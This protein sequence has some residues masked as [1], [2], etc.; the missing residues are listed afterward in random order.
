MISTGSG[1]RAADKD[2]RIVTLGDSITRGVRQGVK[3]EETFSAQ[4]QDRLRKEGAKV[5]VINLG[6]GG[7]RS[8]QALTRLNAAVIAQKPCLVAIMYGTN[9]S[10]V[11]QGKKEPRLTAE[12]YGMNLRKLVAELRRKGIEP[13]LMTPPRWGA[14]A[15]NGAADNPNI[16]LDQFVRVCRVVA[17]ETKTPLVDHN[18]HWSMSS[19]R[20]IDIGE[21]TTDQCHPNPRGHRELAELMLPFLRDRV[22]FPP[23]GYLCYRATR[24][25]TIDGK[26]DEAAWKDA[27]WSDL[28]VDIEGDRKPRPRYRT[29]VKM[30]WDD[31]CLYIAAELEEPHVWATIKEHDSV[32]FHDNDFEVFLDPDGDSHLYAELEI[33]AL[34]TTWDLL[35]TKPYKDA[36]RAITAWEIKGLKTAVHVDGTLNDPRDKDRG[37]TVEIAWPWEGLKE[38]TTMP[39]PPRDGDQWRINFSRVEWEHEIVEGKY[40]KV[41]GKREDNWVWSP[42]GVIDMH[43]PE[44]W[45]YLQFSTA[46]SGTVPFRPDPAGEAK[47]LLHRVYYAQRDH[48]QSRGSWAT[49]LS[50]LG[51]SHLAFSPLGPYQLESTSTSFEAS[52][53]QSRPGQKSRRWRIASDARVWSD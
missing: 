20:G 40:R 45:G 15:K 43:R 19:Q 16:L 30:L 51:L 9:D 23:R 2:I 6:I 3:A 46:P 44:T 36:G 12:Q 14:K 34:N 5:E 31:R 8:D 10:Y 17:T 50:D 26:L 52:V 38:L 13:I 35:L 53:L 21:W 41:K 27:P 7:E 11:D 24:P 33:N 1:A 37:W 48:R 49:S 22:Y 47:H 25:I 42:Q 18:L 29:R 39:V 32:I 28:F 4:L